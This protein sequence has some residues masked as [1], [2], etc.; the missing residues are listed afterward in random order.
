MAALSLNCFKVHKE[1]AVTDLKNCIEV[2][3]VEILELCSTVQVL[4]SRVEE[5]EPEN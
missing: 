3:K 5:T 1:S 2:L 4:S